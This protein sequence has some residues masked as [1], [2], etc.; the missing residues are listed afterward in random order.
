MLFLK[1]Y[2]LRTIRLFSL[3]KLEMMILSLKKSSLFFFLKRFGLRKITRLFIRLKPI[4]LL[5]SLIKSL[6]RTSLIQP[7]PD[8]F[9]NSYGCGHFHHQSQ[10]QHSV[11]S[12]GGR[13]PGRGHGRNGG[14]GHGFWSSNKP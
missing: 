8:L 7:F 4:W 14:G 12:R 10:F 6:K 11:P 9:G 3:L 13:H 2:L 5:H 1:A